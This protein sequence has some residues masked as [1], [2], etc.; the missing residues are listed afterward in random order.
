VALAACLGVRRTEDEAVTHADRVREYCKAQCIDPARAGGQT[1]VSIRAGDIH[2]VLGFKNR[3]PLVCGALGITA[4]EQLA[5]VE[6]VGIEGPTNGA[7]A[8][9]T[10]R[11]RWRYGVELRAAPDRGLALLAPLAADRGN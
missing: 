10:F 4:F 5:K 2:S 11:L 8:V 1:T 3:M 6:R 9:F 7:N